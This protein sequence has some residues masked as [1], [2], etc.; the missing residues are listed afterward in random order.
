MSETV[1]VGDKFNILMTEWF[2]DQHL[3]SF[4]IIQATKSVK[5]ASFDFEVLIGL[6]NSIFAFVVLICQN[7]NSKIYPDD[8]W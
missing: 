3:K 2:S 4:A 5:S 7:L 1:Y 6:L 8:P